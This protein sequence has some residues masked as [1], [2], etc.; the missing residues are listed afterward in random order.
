MQQSQA[1][2][3]TLNLN[4]SQYPG[5][6]MINNEN[7]QLL[8]SAVESMVGNKGLLLHDPENIGNHHRALEMGQE[9]QAI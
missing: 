2:N 3:N 8:I 7:N 5:S 9:S 6:V 4:I 1:I